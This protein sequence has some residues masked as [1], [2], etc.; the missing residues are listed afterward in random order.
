MRLVPD[1][2]NSAPRAPQ[3][4]AVLREK[5]QFAFSSS[6]SDGALRALLPRCEVSPSE[7]QADC[8]ADG[9]FVDALIKS[10]FRIERARFSDDFHP[11]QSLLYLKR[12]L[13]SPPADPD[14][15]AFR[16][17]ILEEVQREP[18]LRVELEAIYRDLAEL[19]ADLDAPDVMGAAYSTRRR[20]DLLMRI[21]QSIDKTADAF[22]TARS[23]ITRVREWAQ[24]FQ[25]TEGYAALRNFADH[26]SRLSSVQ[27]QFQ[28]GLD[29]SVRSLK[30]L[31]RDDN[32]DNP[33]Y[34][35]AP[36]R[37]WNALRLWVR[38]AKASRSAL[39]ARLVQTVFDGIEADL[40]HVLY[41]IGHLEFYLGA[42]AFADRCQAN[43]SASPFIPGM[44]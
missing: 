3:N 39:V 6:E 19:R 12:I 37:L 17:Q 41:L 23:G 43:S 40:A 16:Q 29:G 28:V 20:I 14:A 38:G 35:S 42:L 10:S 11:P 5:L 27:L 18:A 44:I 8:F 36:M 13:L 33:L 4:L 9:L 2:L 22:A 7:W 26:E 30:I 1:I 34:Q 25:G 21:K 24:D 32:R 31:K 15:I